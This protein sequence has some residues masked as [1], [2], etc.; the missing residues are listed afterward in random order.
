MSMHSLALFGKALA[1]GMAVAAPV[2]PMSVLCMRHTLMQGW[3]YGLAT[4]AGIAIG[5]GA[6]ALVAN[7]GL[8]GI[9]GFMASHARPLRFA[10]GLFLLFL[11]ARTFLTREATRPPRPLGMSSIPS[12]LGGAALLTL[13]N[14]PTLVTFAALFTSLTPQTGLRAEPVAL[15]V[16]GVCTGSLLWWS[17]PVAALSVL[18]RALAP[19]RLWIDRSA[20]LV[21]GV[22][23]ISELWPRP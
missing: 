1:F 3:G 18:R 4:G 6:Y 16:A 11:G 12:A 9:S 15:T 17:G 23:G 19:L 14:P 8:A 7:L 20:G 2:G 21:L 5:D 10:A 13:A 22:F